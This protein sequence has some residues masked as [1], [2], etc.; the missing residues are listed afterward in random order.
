[1]Q[2]LQDT[3]K[4]KEKGMLTVEAA[5]LVPIIFFLIMAMFYIA[6]YYL[7]E[8]K[9][10]GSCDEAMEFASQSVGR[11]KDLTVGSF[12]MAKRNNGSLYQINYTRERKELEQLIQEKL[13]GRLLLLSLRKV[14]V[15]I[16]EYQI[17]LQIKLQGK[18]DIWQYLHLGTVTY[19]YRRRV[20]MGNY[21]DW[22]RKAVIIK[23]IKENKGEDKDGR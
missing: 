19:S 13:K 2:S 6:L 21:S 15:S 20:E 3:V 10:Y 7:D 8:A 9:V 22:L 12:S 17:Q 14:K 5:I 4:G 18:T 16:N 11:S 23:E 1:M